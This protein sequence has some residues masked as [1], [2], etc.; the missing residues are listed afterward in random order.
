MAHS[1]FRSQGVILMVLLSRVT[2]RTYWFEY[3]APL[4]LLITVKM[5]INLA[6][7]PSRVIG[8]V[9]NGKATLSKLEPTAAR[10]TVIVCILQA[11]FVFFLRR[12]QAG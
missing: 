7:S 10:S 6:T 3:P 2:S 11:L 8:K 4:P 1:H 12:A 9:K 5:F